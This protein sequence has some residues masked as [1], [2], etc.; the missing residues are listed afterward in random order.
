MYTYIYI[1]KSYEHIN[2]FTLHKFDKFLIKNVLS[3]YNDDDDDDHDHDYVQ[4]YYHIEHYLVH[5]MHNARPL[6]RI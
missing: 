4:N 3:D 5:H 1:L 6:Y 2:K